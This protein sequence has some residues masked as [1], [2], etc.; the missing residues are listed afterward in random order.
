VNKLARYEIQEVNDNNRTVM[1]DFLKQDVIKHAF[2]FYD[3]QYAQEQTKMYAAFENGNP[4]GYILTYTGSEFPSVVIECK[5]TIASELIEY[6]PKDKFIIHA[7]P[8]LLQIIAR[9]FPRAK[10]YVE[11][12]MLV[13]KGE[14][15][16][17]KSEYMRRLQTE[18]DASKLFTLLETR[19]DRNAA[20]IRKYFDWIRKMPLYGVFINDELVSYA[21]SFI[22]LPQ[23][24]VIGGVYT[25]P[26]Y[27]SKGYATQA[28]SAIT[29]EALRNAEAAALFVRTDNN[30]A[31]KVYEK[32]GYRK[33]GEKIWIDV[34]TGLKP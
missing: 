11:D 32:I 25:N 12:W 24:W 30:P 4:Q 22:Q 33:I 17:Q 21:G 28:T 10:H 16:F 27:R 29:E 2:A 31:K 1:M 34:G 15:T 23:L 5:N 3:I 13:K 26:K 14:A 20:S 6:V 8:N 18:E 9:E 19:T 7:P